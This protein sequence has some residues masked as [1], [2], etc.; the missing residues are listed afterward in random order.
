VKR[1]SDVNNLPTTFHYDY[2]ASDYE[3]TF[4]SSNVTISSFLSV[5]YLVQR[6][7]DPLELLAKRR[8]RIAKQIQQ[9]TQHFNPP[10]VS[11]K[12]TADDANLA[13]RSSSSLAPSIKKRSRRQ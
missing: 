1:L 3:R 13:T 6:Y 11:R 12:R 8:Q 9:Q 10:R 4:S 2:L 7:L 5:V